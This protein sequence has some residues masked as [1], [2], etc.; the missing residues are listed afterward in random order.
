MFLRIWFL[1]NKEYDVIWVCVCVI[2]PILLSP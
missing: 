2:K 1:L